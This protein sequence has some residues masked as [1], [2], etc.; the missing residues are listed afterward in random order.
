MV[1]ADEYG[2]GNV[3]YHRPDDHGE[4]VRTPAIDRLARD[5]VILNRHYVGTCFTYTITL[6]SL[7]TSQTPSLS[8]YSHC[9][10]M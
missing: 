5:G 7:Y 4:E 3:G 8:F 10:L 6:H 2:W 1:L 9:S